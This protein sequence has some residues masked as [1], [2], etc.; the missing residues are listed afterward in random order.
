MSSSLA[1]QERPARP[2]SPAQVEPAPALAAASLPYGRHLIEEDDVAAVVAALR[3][4]LLAQGPRV[5]AFEAALATCVGAAEAVACSSGTAA[6]HLALASLDVGPGD[7]CIVP[8]VTFL[9]TATA[10]LFCGAEA[11]FADV[12]PDTGLMTPQTLADA[13]KRARGK[14]RLRAILPVHL[15]GRLCDMGALAAEAAR[16]GALFVEDACHALGSLDAYGAMAGAC[17]LAEAACFS[18]HPVKTIAAGEGGMVTLNDP[19]RAERMRRLRNHGVTR[20]AAAMADAGSFDAAGQPNPWSYEQLELGFNYRMNEMEAAL[21]LS[22]LNKLDR[23]ITRRRA[24]AAR[25]DRLLA[26]L[27]GLVRPVATPPGHTP[28]PHLYSVLIDFAAAGVD[29]AALIRTL[30]AAGVGT[31]VHY[32]P[33]YRQ[34]A[35]RHRYGEMRLPGAEAYYARTLAL[36]LFPAMADSHVDQVVLALAQALGAI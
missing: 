4:D 24:L 36:P 34:P 29:R 20:D 5:A 32:I 11:V 18:F 33:L 30:V 2:S 8:A 23:F 10:A 3:S 27:A 31:Q 25:Y 28:A 16:S 26:P 7:V 19:A 35:L 13:M 15:G 6:L 14:G 21:G 1:R 17:G 12:D 22:Q 9:S